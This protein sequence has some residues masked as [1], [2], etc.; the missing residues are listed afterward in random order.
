M[1]NFLCS[2]W[3]YV[4]TLG[5]RHFL[6]LFAIKCLFIYIR[7]Y[8]LK[9]LLILFSEYRLNYLS[10]F[11]LLYLK[12]L[13]LANQWCVRP[14]HLILLQMYNR[15]RRWPVTSLL[16]LVVVNL[17]L[18]RRIDLFIDAGNANLL[19]SNWSKRLNFLH[20]LWLRS[21]MFQLGLLTALAFTIIRIFLKQNH[22]LLMLL[23]EYVLLS[24]VMHKFGFGVTD[25]IWNK[26]WL[27]CFLAQS[28]ITFWHN[29]IVSYLG[30]LTLSSWFNSRDWWL[31]TFQSRPRLLIL[32]G[33]RFNFYLLLDFNWLQRRSLVLLRR[34][35][36]W[37][38]S[39]HFRLGFWMLERR[40][41]QHILYN[42]LA[43]LIRFGLNRGFSSRPL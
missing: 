28:S 5:Q 19:L 11:I 40:L 15:W 35:I 33:L 25:F 16:L 18:T 2:W 12:L 32:L 7:S 24:L 3:Q 20:N 37:F 21:I 27:T 43:L 36:L 29:Q 1:G 42:D 23:K 38:R 10:P 8:L 34:L 31:L 13:I 17:T 14:F 22:L 41:V 39:V 30:V 6:N 26:S 9:L 4:I